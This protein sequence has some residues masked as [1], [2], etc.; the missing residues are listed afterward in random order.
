MT[1]SAAVIMHAGRGTIFNFDDWIFVMTREG[2]R[3]HNL[4]EPHNEHLSAVPV[5]IYKVLFETVGLDDY[6]AFRLVLMLM[7]LGCGVLLF[8][9]ARPRVG[10]WLAVAVTAP[11]MLMGPGHWDI[12]WAFQIG[13]VGSLL[14]GLGALLAIDRGTRRGDIVACALL[15][16]ALGSSSVGIPIVAAMAVEVLVRDDRRQRIWLVGIPLL[17]YGAW[18]LKYGQTNTT[19]SAIRDVPAW[20]MDGSPHAAGAAVGFPVEWGRLFAAA[21]GVAVI[22]ELGRA[23]RINPRLLALV[24]MPIFFWGAAALSRSG[25]PVTPYE[26]RYLL[27]L[28]LFFVLIAVE[29]A[30]RRPIA[31]RMALVVAV[32]LGAGALNNSNVLREGGTSLR[33]LSDKLNVGLT[34][35]EIA[36]PQ[37][38]PEAQPDPG[39]Y[40]PANRYFQSTR[41][42]GSTPAWT[43]PEMLRKPNAIRT[44]V[45]AAEARLLGVQAQ[46]VPDAPPSSA[47]TP[48]GATKAAGTVL[49]AAGVVFKAGTAPVEVRLVRFGSSLSKDP[50]TTVAPGANGLLRIPA[51]KAPRPWRFAAVSQKPFEWCEAA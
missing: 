15:A 39:Q 51:D 2:W 30:S 29:L 47:C 12:L 4:L 11:V 50:Q 42:Y 22:A 1:T 49:P 14:A 17:L 20:I 3:P 41:H 23:A 45:D 16:V 21:L 46:S 38:G 27:P 19:W 34:A 9:Y 31:T 32:V 25:T 33:S 13:Y 48:V 36:G 35:M 18:Y 6:W 37:V 10:P 43:I 7:V 26:S 44:G 8:L 28:G 24:A 40:I 5:F